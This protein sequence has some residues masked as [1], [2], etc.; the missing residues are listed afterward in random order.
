MPAPKNPAPKTRTRAR[1]PKAPV[2]VAPD[3]EAPLKKYQ[4][5]NS[6]AP[7]AGIVMVVI[8]IILVVVALFFVFHSYSKN[9]TNNVF[10]NDSE[11]V[12]AD[13]SNYQVPL[14]SNANDSATQQNTDSFAGWNSYRDASSTYEF[15]YPANWKID[16]ANNKNIK[17]IYPDATDTESLITL[18]PVKK[19][20]TEYLAALDKISLTAYEGKPS[21]EI[22]NEQK[23]NINGFEAVKRLQKLNAAD[24]E[25]KIT[26]IYSNGKILSFSLVRPSISSDWSEAYDLILSSFKFITPSS[27]ATTSTPASGSTTAVTSSSTSYKNQAYGFTIQYDLG[28]KTTTTKSGINFIIGN[29]QFLKVNGEASGMPSLVSYHP[30]GAKV[31]GQTTIGGKEAMKFSVTDSSGLTYVQ[32][33][34]QLSGTKWLRI[35]YKGNEGSVA[36]FEKII[37]SIKF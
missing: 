32:Y 10:N 21:V 31:A 7:T 16:T 14:D 20:L 2:P 18:Q 3:L 4:P 11:Q 1:L 9:R 17:L 23:T 19:T 34:I 37:S 28:L 5:R 22:K 13:A 24:L 12:G 33:V 15:K 35:E 29:N 30:N 27:T 26:Y 25:Q 8:I 36:S 6:S